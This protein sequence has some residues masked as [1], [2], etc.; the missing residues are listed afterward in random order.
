MPEESS[1]FIGGVG[2]FG[3]SLTGV[4]FTQDSMFLESTWNCVFPG[5]ISVLGLAIAT[6]YCTYFIIKGVSK[7]IERINSILMPLLFIILII[8]VVRA[9]TLPNAMDGV[10]FLFAPK[11]NILCDPLIWLQALGQV[12]FTTALGIGFIITYG[13][14]MQKNQNIQQN[15]YLVAFGDNLASILAGLAIFPAVFAFGLSP[16]TGPRL[17]FII[18]PQV[19]A[20]MPF[21][22][23]FGVLFFLSFAIAAL[24]CTKAA[25]EVATAYLIDEYHLSRF[26]AAIIVGLAQFLIGVGSAISYPIWDIFDWSWTIIPPLIGLLTSIFVGWIWRIDRFIDEEKMSKIWIYLL[27]FVVPIGIAIV[28]LGYLIQF[29][30]AFLS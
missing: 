3:L 1:Q 21:G 22:Y 13:S 14:Y 9:L 15:T 6:M 26:K 4:I 11:I 18:L 10:I 29:I 20:K 19:F 8:G 16:G 7:G 23:I 27:K 25:F 12:Y 30:Q 2:Q 17:A 24:E 5:P 28:F